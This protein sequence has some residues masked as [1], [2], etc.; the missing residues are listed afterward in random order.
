MI[1]NALIHIIFSN[2]FFS[3]QNEIYKICAGNMGK[4][5]IFRYISRGSTIRGRPRIT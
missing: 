2:Y 3:E 1:N 4:R 5:I